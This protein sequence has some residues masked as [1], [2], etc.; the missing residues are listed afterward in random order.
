MERTERGRY[1]GERDGLGV[2]GLTS[3][4]VAGPLGDQPSLWCAPLGLAARLDAY[5]RSR[6]VG[7]LAELIARYEE[8]RN[9]FLP[10]ILPDPEM[11]HRH[12]GGVMSWAP[13]GFSKEFVGRLVPVVVRGVVRYPIRVQEDAR[14][15][16]RVVWNAAGEEVG[17]LPPP[18]GYDPWT[19]VKAQ[20]GK[21]LERGGEG[22]GT[23]EGD[24]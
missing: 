1:E 3:M 2:G 24:F 16:E 19:F 7:S 9:Q 5:A 20:Y 12:I 8:D 10:M 15:R 11:P 4:G 13:E 21:E 17:R 14:T 23:A 6:Q 18:L 22:S